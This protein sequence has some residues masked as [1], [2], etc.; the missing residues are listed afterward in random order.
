MPLNS[1]NNYSSN[2]PVPNQ[3]YHDRTGSHH[4]LVT[5]VLGNTVYYTRYN[6]EYETSLQEF[7]HTWIL[8]ETN[9]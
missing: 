3:H 8:N 5:Q 7:L 2:F 1:S 9:P 4:I 6:R